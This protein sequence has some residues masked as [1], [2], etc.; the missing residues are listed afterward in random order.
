YFTYGS[1][2]HD[3]NI[4]PLNLPVYVGE[5]LA[6]YVLIDPCAPPTQ[7]SVGGWD[8]TGRFSFSSWGAPNGD[9]P[10][11]AINMGALPAAGTWQRM[12]VP[13]SLWQIEE[14]LLG[15]LTV[16][17]VDGHAWFDHIGRN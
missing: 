14:H 10:G 3:F 15:S 11:G 7:I 9:E 4:A 5:S 13:F 16:S 12:E 1:A 6:F 17:Y 2:R 8:N